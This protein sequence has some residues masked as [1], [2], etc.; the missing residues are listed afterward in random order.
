MLGRAGLCVWGTPPASAATGVATKPVSRY[1]YSCVTSGKCGARNSLWSS[2]QLR[3]SRSSAQATRPR[4]SRSGFSL[5]IPLAAPRRH[6]RSSPWHS[7]LSW[8][9]RWASASISTRSRWTWRVMP[10]TTCRR[11]LLIICKSASAKWQPDLVVPIGA[12]ASIFVAT[13]R[14]RLF[15]ET[16]IVYASADRR[17]LPPGALEKNAAYI[18]QVYEIPGML[19]DMLQI[20]PA[21]KKLRS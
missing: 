5:F 1:G 9:K 4:R 13:Y 8:W 16:P 18:G 3:R 12:P 19:E 7:R 15:P 14:D 10:T 2:R 20:A 17:L 21:T 6:S 11:R